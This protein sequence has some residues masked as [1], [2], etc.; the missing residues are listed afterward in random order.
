MSPDA[1]TDWYDYDVALLYCQNFQI[2]NV[3]AATR[4]VA[5]FQN[6]LLCIQETSLQLTDSA[7]GGMTEEIHQLWQQMSTHAAVP[8][9]HS[10]PRQEHLPDAP[11]TNLRPCGQRSNA[12]LGAADIEKTL[13]AAQLR[14]VECHSSETLHS[15]IQMHV[16]YWHTPAG[17]L[18][19][20]IAF[21][22]HAIMA[23]QIGI[24]LLDPNL[25]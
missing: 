4:Q 18:P 12:F 25:S 13:S 7:V 23:L 10:M 5:M 19:V 9:Q 22:V 17:L 1:A 11:C 6:R 21:D 24:M 2:S 15:H 3:Q 20:H 16:L 8:S 14:R